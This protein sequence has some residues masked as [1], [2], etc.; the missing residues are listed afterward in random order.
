MTMQKVTSK[1]G[2]TIAY[3]QL[4]SGPAVILV[5]GAFSYRL[6]PGAMELANLLSRHFT[7]INYD[8]R[9]RGD[10][11]D[12]KPYVVQREIEDLDALIQA[13]GGSA[14]VWGMSSGAVLALKAAKSGLNIKKLA[15][16]DPPFR[17]DNSAPLPP[18][19]FIPHVTQLINEN[20]RGDAVRYF[21]TKGM[22]AP[23]FAM[24][25]MRLMPGLWKRLTAVANTLPY[26]ALI[27]EGYMAG[28]PLRAEEWNSITTPTLVMDGEKSAVQLKNAAKALADVLPNAQ[29]RTLEGLS[30]TNVQMTVIAPVVEAFFN[31]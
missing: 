29:Y 25:F 26:D 21:M 19:D 9:G 8:R 23:G 3:D 13:A 27:L 14:Y 22:G 1:D 6:Y 4:G 16:Y 12:T 2:T 31:S 30:H 18:A 28:E 20:R 15:L 17:V 10:S 11:G 7:V 24:I 5:N